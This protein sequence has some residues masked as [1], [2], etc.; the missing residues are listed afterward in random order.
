MKFFSFA[1]EKKEDMWNIPVAT[2]SQCPVCEKKKGR[3]I[4]SRWGMS[5]LRL[6]LPWLQLGRL[7]LALFLS[8]FNALLTLCQCHW[9]L[10]QLQKLAN[11]SLAQS[12]KA[13]FAVLSDAKNEAEDCLETLEFSNVDLLTGESCAH[14]DL[15]VDPHVF[16]YSVDLLICS[17]CHTHVMLSFLQGLG[18]EMSHL[19]VACTAKLLSADALQ[20]YPANFLLFCYFIITLIST[21]P[22]TR[23]RA[24]P[25][26]L[27]HTHSFTSRAM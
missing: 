16:L 4:E 7:G 5:M 23:V 8:M 2:N 22:D 14:V 6:L 17:K 21:V 10:V 26:G 15:L 13:W 19:H 20:L 12:C 1:V 18:F 3:K 11:M 9:L 27:Y 25:Y 24:Q